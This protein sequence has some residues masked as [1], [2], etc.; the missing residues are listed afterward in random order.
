MSRKATK[1]PILTDR[2]RILTTIIRELAMAQSLKPHAAGQWSSEPY[3]DK[4]TKRYHVHF[5]PW[6]Q[7]NLNRGDLVL[8]RTGRSVHEWTIGFYVEA[9]P[10]EQGGAVIREIGSERLC[11]YYNEAF[12]PIIGLTKTQL[13]EGER[14]RFY[15]KVLEAFARGREYTYRFGGVD[16]NEDNTAV[17]WVREVF[18][19]LDHDSVPFAVTIPWTRKTSVKAILA[20]MRKQGYGTRVFERKARLPEI[21]S[22]TKQSTS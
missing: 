18:G 9:L 16:F 15:E 20:E 13:L 14:Y 6:K 10:A 8:A 11:D 12:E 5:A 19:G 3:W 22:V 1:K 2:E 17:I 21:D 4:S 7:D